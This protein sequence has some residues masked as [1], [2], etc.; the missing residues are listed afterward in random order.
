MREWSTGNASGGDA[1]ASAC[2]QW[3]S[4]GV[5]RG[6]WRGVVQA[7]ARGAWSERRGRARAVARLY[8]GDARRGWR[9]SVVPAQSGGGGVVRRHGVGGAEGAV[10]ASA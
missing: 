6:R 3:A 8:A 7:A 5:A 2:K 4:G 1:W 10:A 9:Q